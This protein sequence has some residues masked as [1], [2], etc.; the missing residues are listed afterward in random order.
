M[1]EKYETYEKKK[2]CKIMKRKVMGSIL[3]GLLILVVVIM[4]GCVEEE[5]T[6]QEP[7]PTDQPTPTVS[8]AFTI[9]C[10]ITDQDGLQM[11]VTDL[12]AHSHDSC[13]S[14]R[15]WVGVPRETDFYWD[16]IPI[17]MDEYI[18]YVPFEVIKSVT[19]QKEEEASGWERYRY[20]LVLSDG[21]V[22]EG[23][24]TK[25]ISD[26]TGECDLGDFKISIGGIKKI[27][28]VHPKMSISAA[29]KGKNRAT[30]Y[31]SDGTQLQLNGSAFVVETRNKNGCY[32]GEKYFNT[33]KF[34]VGVVEYNIEW[35]KIAA[36]VFAES[37]KPT[38]KKFKLIQ[39]S[40]S[41]YVGSAI[42]RDGVEGI[43]TQGNFKL[44]VIV[45]FTSRAERLLFSS[46]D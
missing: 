43:V 13:G 46:G 9:E 5:T 19:V 45:P 20:R 44:R 17:R 24:P 35:D 29:P 34:E 3:M 30:L 40:G 36:I 33:L 42:N 10:Q 15:Y 38:P 31:L 21:T 27:N 4:S 1:N 16:F 8:P 12:K 11:S 32:T 25:K 2:R 28:F 22:I 14:F 18:L 41:E 39:Q 7:T 6:P 23:T 26:F 37:D